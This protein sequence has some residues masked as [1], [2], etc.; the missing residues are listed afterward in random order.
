MKIN[1]EKTVSGINLW[2]AEP[3]PVK[4]LKPL[5]RKIAAEGSVLLKNDGILPLK[6]GTKVAL[7]GR[8]QESYIKSGT[9]SGG[10][11]N[12]LTKP[13]IL[14]SFSKNGVFEIDTELAEVYQGWIKNNPFDNGHGWA[15]EPWAQTEM[16]VS[17]DLTKKFAAKNDV[18]VVIIN[19]TAGEDKDNSDTEGSYRLNRTEMELLKNVTDSFLKTVVVLNV[20]NVIDIS[21]IES[22]NVSALLYNWQGG[23]EGADALADLLAGKISPSGK[24]PDTQTKTAGDYISLEDFGSTEDIIYCEDIYVGYRYFET[25]AP[26]KVL[27]PFGFGL[28]YTT[29]ETKYTAKAEDE[30]INITATVTNTGNFT[31]KEVVQVYFG[32]PNGKLGTP[33]KQLIAFKKTN[34]LKPGESQTLN[35]TFKINQM[36]SYDDSG[37]TGNRF[38]YVLESGDYSIFAG[39]DVRS[40]DKVLTYTLEKTAVTEKLD[41]A[42]APLTPFKR[43]VSKCEKGERIAVFED[44]PLNSTDLEKRIAENK[45]ADIPFTGDTGIKLIDVAKGKNTLDEFVAQMTEKDLFNIVCGE[46]MNSPKVAGSGSAFGGVTDSLLNLGIPICSTSD[47]PSGLRLRGFPAASQVPNGTLFAASFDEKLTEEIFELLGVEMFSYKNDTLLAPGMNIHR[48]PLCGRNFEYFSEDPLLSG[49]MAAAETRGIKSTG[50]TTAIKHFCCN[51]QEKGRHITNSVVSERALRE[52]YLKGFEIAVK[53]GG[54]TSVMTSY[55]LINGYHAASNYDLTTTVLR[56]EWGFEGMVMTDWWAECNEKPVTA[57]KREKGNRENLTDMIRCQNDIYKVCASAEEK[58]HNLKEGLVSG[59]ITIGD[60]QRSAK[61]ILLYILKSPTFERFVD[62]GCVIPV[63]EK[64]NPEDMEPIYKLEN[65]Q[66]ESSITAT[67]G[68]EKTCLITLDMEIHTNSIAQSS[69]S[70]KIDDLNVALRMEGTN[71]NLISVKRNIKV[72][73]KKHTLTFTF[74]PAVKLKNITVYKQR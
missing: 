27:Y 52:I 45:M 30:N 70:V 32:A 38:C 64:L 57:I 41:Q 1:K 60:L 34:D 14:E 72:E 37:V 29:F 53:E 9:G 73:N 28:T 12:I 13:C 36:A 19:R 50:G 39:T 24:L 44:T 33:K 5:C 42:M 22:L 74:P 25:F 56:K 71:G 2:S 62:G 48:H 63:F 59:R 40:A 16:P 4:A 8:I 26:E 49:K 31:A 18:A 35:L 23:E 15:T 17:L 61:N 69:I 58:K 10:Q 67:F 47:G 6:K 66:N 20:G 65:P 51:N 68:D 46:G 7:F 55:N 43:L 11:V 21:Y 54:A 3:K